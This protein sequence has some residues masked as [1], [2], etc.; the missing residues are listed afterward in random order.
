MSAQLSVSLHYL[1]TSSHLL[2]LGIDWMTPLTSNYLSPMCLRQWVER[3]TKTP[4]TWL[5][6]DTGP[7]WRSDQRKERGATKVRAGSGEPGTTGHISVCCLR[8]LLPGRSKRQLAGALNPFS[9]GHSS[10]PSKAQGFC[11]RLDHACSAD[12]G[13]SVRASKRA[14]MQHRPQGTSCS[15]DVKL[16]SGP[17][18]VRGPSRH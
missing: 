2:C 17:P 18:S 1:S 9:S 16:K 14:S 15:L 4:V 5:L 8:S 7:K 6:A 10:S 13:V 3:Y 11:P 12:S